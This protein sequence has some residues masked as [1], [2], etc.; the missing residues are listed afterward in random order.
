MAS[1]SP[2]DQL[3]LVFDKWL[4]LPDHGVVEITLATI[5]ANR[6][7]GDP[8]WLLL[9]GPPSS[10]K[11]EVLNTLRKLPDMYWAS[12]LT[13]AALLSGT[14]S[15]EVAD[16]ATG[17]LLREIGPFGILAL[18]DFTSVLSMN[19]DR[20]KSLLAALREI[21]DGEWSRHLG[22]DGARTLRWDGKLGLLGGVTSAID[23]CHS[24]MSEMGHR[25][26]LYRLPKTDPQAQAERAIQKTGLESQM[27]AELA[28]AVF[29]F[30]GTIKFDKLPA[31]SPH[32]NEWII[33]LASLVVN[34]RSAVERHGNSRDVEL[35]HDAES[36][37][38]LARM[39]AQLL[40]GLM[41]VGVRQPRARQ[42]I[43]KVGMDC[44][45]PV[46]RLVVEALMSSPLPLALE[47][48]SD[49]T[50]YPP[51]TI[52]RAL[53]ELV[54]HGILECDKL[55]GDAYKW[56]VEAYW[57]KQYETA[58]GASAKKSEY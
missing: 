54:C 7:E 10:G 23:S 50:N 47:T 40:R 39:L 11:T 52:R 35:I 1:K 15:K 21:F 53:E 37:A 2:L 43:V 26:A 29:K 6:I 34:S 36:P 19:R 20:R 27:R 8:V 46:R 4:H 38:R 22:T 3:L 56:K 41:L 48:I 31:L 58:F 25:F 18:K 28:D 44:I 9:T 51:Q 13:E 16:D 45:P 55:R 14:S 57:R 24:V 32:E 17:G 42:L 5:A 49:G 30:F 12:T 33:A